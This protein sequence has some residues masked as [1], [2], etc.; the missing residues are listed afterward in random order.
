MNK[1]RIGLFLILLMGVLIVS[2]CTTKEETEIEKPLVTE[3][4][5]IEGNVLKLL[6]Q[7][8]MDPIS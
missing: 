6:V 3:P 4:E 7:P 1:A 2:G 8:C 5:V